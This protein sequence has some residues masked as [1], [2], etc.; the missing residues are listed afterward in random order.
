MPAKPASAFLACHCLAARTVSRMLCSAF[1][2]RNAR[3]PAR[4]AASSGVSSK[5]MR[6]PSGRVA[7]FELGYEPVLPIGRGADRGRE[8]L[9]AAII[10]VAIRLPGEPH[11]A[12][13][14]DVLLGG[15]MERVGRGH[16][17][18]RGGD[19]QL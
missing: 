19:R 16:A 17:R 10:E 9:G 2:S 6:N 5:S 7:P 18:G 14:L 4:N 13:S 11:A 8:Q 15:E 3:T 1:A 12:V